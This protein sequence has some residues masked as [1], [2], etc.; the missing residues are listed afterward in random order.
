MFSQSEENYLKAIFNLEIEFQ[1]FVSTNTIAERMKTKAS[2]VTDML[3]KL[4]KKNLVVYKKYQG[5]KLSRSGKKIAI[6]II[7]KHRLW[8]CFLVDKLHFNW[9]EVHEIAEQLEHIRSKELIL[10][11][12]EYLDFPTIDPHGDPIPDK[13]G[14]INFHKGNT[15]ADTKVNATG[16]VIGVKDSSNDFLKFLKKL[17]ISL[18][19]SIKI[20]DKESFDQ[21][22]TIVIDNNEINISHQTA[23]NI[24]IK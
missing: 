17:N 3:K 18:G 6:S 21:S 10:R 12:E 20:I 4:A 7:R 2:S 1:D 22:L 14:K 15:L 16:V 5:A 13:N 11:L 8:E 19:T 23:K 9:D 24:F